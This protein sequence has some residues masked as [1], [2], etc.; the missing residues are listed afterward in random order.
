MDKR[1]WVN[2]GLLV[3]II[4][5]SASFF[6]S[7]DNTE[8][9]LPLLSNVK[10]EEIVHIEVLRKGL[11]N[12]IFNKEGDVWYMS[13]PQ[14]FLA[15]SARIDAMLQLLKTESHG[16]LKSDDV[17]LARFDLA[18]PFITL[19]LGEHIFEFG[20]TDAIDQRRYVLFDKK[21]HLT[22]DF[23]YQQ[24]TTNATFFTDTKILPV[25]FDIKVIEFPDNKIEKQDTQWKTDSLIDI[26]P[27]QLKNIIFNWE[28]VN[29]ISVGMYTQPETESH[30][31]VTST[32]DNF[33][34]FVIV[35]TEPHLVLGRKDLGI[36]YHL[37]SDDAGRL[38]LHENN[39]ME[40]SSS[41]NLQLIER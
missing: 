20:N 2:V 17:D 19:K 23:L 28:N 22:N 10:P 15:N 25:G 18:D 21:I 39:N 38:L 4:I 30:I 3:F 16:Q 36:Q 1:I 37:G 32:N 5:L 33:I 13:A 27:D 40:N 7:E 14:K 26:K 31:I 12:F 41:S 34:V 9:P 35:S 11:N 6:I 24:L 29:A 8:Q